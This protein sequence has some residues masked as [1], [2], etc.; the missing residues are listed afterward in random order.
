MPDL[1]QAPTQNV[2][3]KRMHSA[4]GA[5]VHQRALDLFQK[6][7]LSSAM[8]A[9][10]EWQPTEPASLAK[11]VLLFRMNILR[12]KILRFQGKFQESLICLSK[13]RYT[14]DLLEDLHF[15]KEAGELIVEIADT[16]RELDDS[17]RAEQMLTAQLQQQYHTPATRA[18]LG[19]S[20]AE[21]LFAQQKFREADRLC[22]EA[23][24]QRL[25]KMARLRLCITA[26]KL[27]HVS[28]D[29]EGAFA[30]WTKA[31][32]AINKF[33]PTSGHA[34]RL[35]YLSLCD[36]LRRQGQQELEE[37]TRAQVAELEALSQDAEATHWIAGLRHWR[38]FIEP[39]VL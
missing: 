29:W 23:E 33:P 1:H 19:L 32:I 39:S 31:L 4:I 26:A 25:S 2:A 12:G 37:A 5:T 27:R 28:S 36:V 22:R 7:E 18:L 6:E 17:A 15:D 34:T 20:L 38:M 21:S 24:S 13:S 30:W 9:L 3:N 10:Q 35:I 16:I 11:E 14:M 8:D